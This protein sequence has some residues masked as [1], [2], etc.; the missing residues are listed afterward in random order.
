MRAIAFFWTLTLFAPQVFGQSPRL[1]SQ[2]QAL[3]RPDQSFA[4]EDSEI[5]RL[6]CVPMFGEVKKMTRQKQE[7]DAF[8]QSCD[9][10]FSDRAEASRFFAER[11]WEYI[12]EGELD[13][14]CYRFNLAYLLDAANSDAYWGMG[15]VCHQKG[16]T[17]EAIRM[18]KKGVSYDSTDSMLL[19]D[20]A[21]LY[22]QHYTDTRD[23]KELDAA[24]TWLG[25]SLTLDTTNANTYLK[26]AL[27]EFHR[28]NYDK[29][30]ENLHKCRAIDV[31][32]LDFDFIQ[33]LSAKKE[34]PQ[35]IFKGKE[36]EK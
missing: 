6:N 30:W 17:T 34:D 14:A 7:Q 19:D 1:V 12:A 4:K 29:S 28:T 31:Q 9:R 11:G 25:K 8:L 36:E 24:F 2:T 33:Q 13:T 27:A 15:V 26:L 16:N 35:G 10:S 32:L 20:L 5:A 23:E 3:A 18:L 21:T 22:I